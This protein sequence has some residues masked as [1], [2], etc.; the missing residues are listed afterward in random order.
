MENKDSCSLDSKFGIKVAAAA[1]FTEPNII[2]LQLLLEFTPITLSFSFPSNKFWC[3]L[4]TTVPQTL[5]NLPYLLACVQSS[6][7]NWDSIESS[8]C[9]TSNQLMWIEFSIPWFLKTRR[10]STAPGF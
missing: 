4:I 7:K 5:P 3:R 2:R 9:I 8:M 6:Y 10:I 1:G